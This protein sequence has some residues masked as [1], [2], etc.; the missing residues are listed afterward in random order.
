M[1]VFTLFSVV[2]FFPCMEEF[3]DAPLLLLCHT[4]LLLPSISLQ[5]H[6]REYCQEGSTL[7]PLH[8]HPLLKQEALLSKQPTYIHKNKHIYSNPCKDIC[9]NHSVPPKTLQSP[10]NKCS[11]V[12]KSKETENPKRK[13]HKDLQKYTQTVQ[14]MFLHT[15]QVCARH[16]Y[17]C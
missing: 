16:S 8:H 11:T 17:A 9:H 1:F 10:M 13:R 2:P 12:T 7:L 6:V 14:R 4:A 5:Q 3:S 15:L